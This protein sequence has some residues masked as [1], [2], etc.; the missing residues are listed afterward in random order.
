[1]TE[2]VCKGSMDL[3]TGCGQCAKC[4][5]EIKDNQEGYWKVVEQLD[6]WQEVSEGLG[7]DSV[8]EALED[9]DRLRVEHAELVDLLESSTKVMEELLQAIDNYNDRNP[10]VHLVS[11][12]FFRCGIRI[13]M[14]RTMLD[15]VVQD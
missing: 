15:N 6:Y 2:L 1:M 3:G 12:S 13:A 5:N 4:L 7:Y 8:C 14:N 10:D 11:P 9:V